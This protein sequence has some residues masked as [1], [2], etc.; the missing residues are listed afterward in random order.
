MGKTRTWANVLAEKK[1]TARIMDV[2]CM[3]AI[4]MIKRRGCW[5]ALGLQRK[6]RCN[7]IQESNLY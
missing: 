1:A 7:K 6:K 5:V 3:F 4:A 2:G